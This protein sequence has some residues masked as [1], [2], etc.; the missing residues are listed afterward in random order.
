[1]MRITSLVIKILTVTF[2]ACSNSK[3]PKQDVGIYTDWRN[4]PFW[5][6]ILKYLVI[7]RIMGRFTSFLTWLDK[8]VNWNNYYCAWCGKPFD[9]KELIL[10]C[11]HCGKNFCPDDIRIPNHRY[12][13][14]PPPGGLR[15]VH[16]ANG[17]IDAYG[18]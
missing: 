17:K 10:K 16:H 5:D 6:Q 18:R 8:K 15:E 2:S 1:M 4:V 7:N 11:T 14:A 13:N 3:L 9:N 12:K